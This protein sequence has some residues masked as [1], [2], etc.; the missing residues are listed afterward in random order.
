[1]RRETDKRITKNAEDVENTKV[2][3][4]WFFTAEAQSFIRGLG[5]GIGDQG[6]VGSKR[7]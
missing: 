6:S 1:M 2:F 3:I 7:Y 4:V 5:S